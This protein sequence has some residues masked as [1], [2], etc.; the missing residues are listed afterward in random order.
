MNLLARACMVEIHRYNEGGYMS[1]RLTALQR[2]AAFSAR[3]RG[4]Q[5]GAWNSG[6]GCASARCIRCGAGL[7]VYNSPIQPEM[8]GAAINCICSQRSAEQAA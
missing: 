8:D 5:L 7:R 1:D 3:L 4:H 2:I 6:D